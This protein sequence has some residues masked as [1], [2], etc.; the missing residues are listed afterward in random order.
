MNYFELYEQLKKDNS[1]IT[2][3]SI[4]RDLEGSVRIVHVTSN[5]VYYYN[6]TLDLYPGVGYPKSRFIKHFIR[7]L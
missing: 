5:L 6:C 1:L 4:W 7:I 2:I 3:G